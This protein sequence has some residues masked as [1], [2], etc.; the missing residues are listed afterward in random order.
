[1][2]AEKTALRVRIA[3][4]TV[5]V[6]VNRPRRQPTGPSSPRLARLVSDADSSLDARPLDKGSQASNDAV[7]SSSE[8]STTDPGAPTECMDRRLPVCSY[9]I[10]REIETCL[11]VARSVLLDGS[12]SE[13]HSSTAFAVD[14]LENVIEVIQRHSSEDCQE[15]AM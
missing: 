9:E 6:G 15:H 5:E 10:I 8:S 7:Q 14:I 12:P 13:I 4:R 1:M 2:T 3:G 11:T